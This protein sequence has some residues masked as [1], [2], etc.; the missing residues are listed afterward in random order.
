MLRIYKDID[1]LPVY[2]FLKIIKTNDLRYLYILEDYHDLSIDDITGLEDI[3]GDIQSQIVDVN[4][5][6]EDYQE[7]IQSQKDLLLMKCDIIE[8][9]DDS[10]IPIMRKTEKQL[11]NKMQS[12]H[13]QT[14]W[15]DIIS[16]ME[17]K[18]K[19]QFDLKKMSVD[20][21]FKYLKYFSDGR[22]SN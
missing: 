3:W 5:V 14:D 1:E 12:K 7:M 15:I 8:S 13:S 21:L 4:G 11:I 19:F 20:R 6:S 10:T 9:G 22:K 2:N 17:I 18:F 16:Q